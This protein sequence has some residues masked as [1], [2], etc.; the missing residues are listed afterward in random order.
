MDRHK[1]FVS[2][3]SCCC[4]VMVY[5]TPPG[6]TDPGRSSYGDAYSKILAAHRR[7]PS[8]SASSV[9]ML[10]APDVDALCASKMLSRLFRQDDVIYT[11]IP[12]AGVEDFTRI[13]NELAENNEVRGAHRIPRVT[14]AVNL[15]MFQ[16]HALVMLNV[17]GYV[18]LP[19]SNWFGDFRTNI[20]IHVIDSIRP[21]NLSSLFGVG[22]NGDRIIVWDD[23]EADRLMNEKKSWEALEVWRF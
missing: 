15:K 3:Y 22:E 8:T 14:S 21:R 18:D 6:Q 1:L 9:M 12:V 20:T 2:Q 13:R 11:I 23:G 16:L 19:S 10:V 17:G 7:S 5:I 4:A